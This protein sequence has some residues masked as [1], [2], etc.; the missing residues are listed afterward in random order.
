MG[1]NFKVKL[2]RGLTFIYAQFPIPHRGEPIAS[3]ASISQLPML[4]PVNGLTR[5]R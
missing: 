3:L 1:G 2:A 4:R 5:L